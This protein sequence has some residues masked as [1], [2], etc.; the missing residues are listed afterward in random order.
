LGD[1]FLNKYY[2]AFDFEQQRIGLAPA[3]ENALDVCQQD[4]F[5]D[6]THFWQVR[7][8]LDEEQAQE[9]QQQQQEPIEGDANDQGDTPTDDY[10]EV[11]DYEDAQQLPT[12]KP[13][14][15]DFDFSDV[16]DASD[17]DG[18]G[19]STNPSPSHVEPPERQPVP[20]LTPSPAPSTTTESS[21][22]A[23]LPGQ[24]SAVASSTD[25]NIAVYVVIA[26]VIAFVAAFIV[27]KTSQRRQQAMFHE[28]WRDAERE[29]V[30]SHR[31]LNYRDHASIAASR[32]SVVPYRDDGF[33]D[34]EQ[35][36]DGEKQDNFV[37]DRD[38]LNKMN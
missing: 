38:M 19:E 33:H 9:E 22:T 29:M 20:H 32:A 5:L 11:F 36:P 24:H 25:S 18:A 30:N 28:T 13:E 31:N 14:D 27:R 2:A 23:E 4:M 26:A 3:A 6:I 7:D 1:A 8:D 17:G 21:F 34:E 35:P 37:L 15:E 10:V 16:T 12:E